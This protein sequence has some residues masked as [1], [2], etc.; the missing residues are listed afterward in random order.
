MTKRTY[1][2]D[3][4]RLLVEETA[5]WLCGGEGR[6]GCARE[7]PEGVK[8]LAHI[9]VIVPTAQS[10]RNLRLALAKR[11]NALGWGGLIPPR[12]EMP[13]SLLAAKDVHGALS[14]SS[15]AVGAATSASPSKPH[16]AGG[17]RV[18]TE[19]EEIA[20]MAATLMEFDL[21]EAPALFP[22]PPKERTCDWALAMAQ[23]LL[24]IYGILGERALLMSDVKCDEDTERWSDLAKVEAAFLAALSAHG[25]TSR[26]QFRRESVRRGCTEEGIEEILLP[27]LV[28]M[29][30]AFAEYL[31][32]SAQT[33]TLLI[34]AD[35]AEADRFDEWGRPTEFFSSPI[36]PSSVKPAPTAIFEAGDVANFF[37]SV[38]AQEAYPALAVCDSEMYPELEGAFQ[39][40]FS[41]D[42]LALRNP[43]CERT[44]RSALGR[45]LITVLELSQRGDYETFSTFIRSGD[46]ARW[47]AKSKGVSPAVV[48]SWVGALDAIQ[49]AHLPQ[50]IDDAINAADAES[51]V[52]WHGDDRV[53][54]AGFRRLAETVREEL[55][56]PFAFLKKI[57][58]T[59]TL[60]EK[61]PSDRELVAA[62]E[63]VRDLRADCASE[64]IPPPMRQ[65]LFV[66]LLKKSAYMLEPTSPN[67]LAALG[68]LEIQW[69][70]EDELVIA[71]FNE[72]CVPENVVGHPFVPNSLRDRLGLSTNERR[73]MRDSFI[74]AQA[75]RCRAPGA[76]HVHLHQI[77]GEKNVTKPSRILFRGISDADLPKLAMRLYAVT[78]GN[79]GAPAKELPSA[80]R[81]PLPFPPKGTVFRERISVTDIDNYMRCPFKFYLKETFGEHS[82][83]RSKELDSLAFGNLCH[84]ALE[85]FAKEGPKDSVDEREIAAFLEAAVRKRLAEFGANLPAIIE[86]QGLAA[87]ER[88]KAFSRIQVARR[89]AG[90][91]IIA[92]EQKLSCRIKGC[93]TTITGKVDR[94]D[95]HETTKELAIID[96]KTWEFAKK[97]YYD[98]LQLPIY[99]AMVETSNLYASDKAHSAKAFYCVLAERAEDTKFDVDH[100]CDEG[101]Q[102]KKEDEVVKQL[103]S[104]AKGIFYPPSKKSEWRKVYGSLIWKTPEEGID[105]EWIA[106]QE[107]RREVAE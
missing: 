88:L 29:Q 2:L 13:N 56:D 20:V 34:H 67:V 81:L 99:R 78:K 47:A 103:T 52:A 39:N 64:L 38:G 65:R 55:R 82:D 43:A 101:E 104:L 17:V 70:A 25:V 95:E 72:G 83:D 15:H 53:A 48:A 44:A 62:A 50:T 73:E 33:V 100:S 51:R 106:D 31:A 54:A 42:E 58:A 46:V 3:P 35:A 90:W 18:A 6:I 4:R 49:N 28:D 14:D 9:M 97:D 105:P 61:N 107:A 16:A 87:I 98:S 96:Y 86:L 57:F 12:I 30:G 22:Q 1:Y 8:S 75:I 10:G 92:S 76:V 32:N 7:T 37:R 63:T 60:D 93:P 102:S 84:N 11:A 41:E 69:C 59:L 23:P 66:E 94:I 68:W 85:D 19:A 26:I 21:D 36:D 89:R 74:F 45:L 71:G 77:D 24:G 5:D 91:R 27:G 80:W 40:Y 79:E